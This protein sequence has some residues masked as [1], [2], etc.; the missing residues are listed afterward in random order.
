[1]IFFPISIGTKSEP[2]VAKFSVS[3]D[4]QFLVLYN[5]SVRSKIIKIFST[6]KS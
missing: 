6:D 1:M 4:D 2:E 3:A 5:V